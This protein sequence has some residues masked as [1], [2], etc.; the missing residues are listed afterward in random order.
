MAVLLQSQTY[1]PNSKWDWWEIGGRWNG[2]IKNNQQK[3]AELKPIVSKGQY[4]EEEL[5]A[6]YPEQYKDYMDML[7]GKSYYKKEY[8]LKR[9]KEYHFLPLLKEI[10]INALFVLK[11]ITYML[12][13]QNIIKCLIT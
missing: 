12:I 2:L 4:T 1:N 11:D 3:L 9:Q 7:N 10:K 5:K 8:I 6:M 13:K